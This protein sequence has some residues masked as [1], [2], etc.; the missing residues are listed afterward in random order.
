MTLHQVNGI[1]LNVEQ[2]GSGPPLVLLHGF[3]GS[4]ET[5]APHVAHIGRSFTT[6]S[7]DLIGHG[8]SDVPADPERY[9]MERCVDDLVALFDELGIASTALLGYSLGARVALNLVVAA[10]ERIHT[11]LLEGAS[12]GIAD[13]LERA[14]RHR[15]DVALADLIERDGL[16]AFVDYWQSQPLFDS[17]QNLPLEVRQH[18]RAA[19]LA[20]DPQGLANSLRG[21]GAGTMEPVWDRLSQ[22][23]TPIQLIVGELD[24][25]YVELSARMAQQMPRASRCVIPG[26]GHAPHLEAPERFDRAVQAW[27]SNAE[28]ESRDDD[29][30]S[31]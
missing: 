29:S 9:R 3:T 19:R 5:W 24:Q 15:A 30:A 18:H 26:A 14:A 12:P 6:Y 10:P 1:N 17:E 22:I 21:M 16:V 31:V 4:S 25:K 11:L 20:N 23:T 2:L 27:F 7:I 13:P 8:R 28:S